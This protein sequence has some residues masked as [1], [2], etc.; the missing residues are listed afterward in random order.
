MF[1]NKIHCYLYVLFIVACVCYALRNE[2][3]FERNFKT[4]FSLGDI[5][6][7]RRINIKRIQYFVSLH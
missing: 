3:V 4:S 2:N 7:Q 6:S 5:L 1:V